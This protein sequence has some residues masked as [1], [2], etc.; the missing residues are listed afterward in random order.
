MKWTEYYTC[1]YI[2][3]VNNDHNDLRLSMARNI[4]SSPLDKERETCD[5]KLK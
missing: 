2:L 3:Y 5:V 1:T 4:E